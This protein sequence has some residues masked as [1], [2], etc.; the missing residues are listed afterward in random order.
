[1]WRVILKLGRLPFTILVTI[2]SVISSVTITFIIDGI[3]NRP[4]PLSGL[5]ASISAPLLLAPLFTWVILG[6]LF[7]IHHMQEEMRELATYDQLTGVY[8]RRAFLEIS[9]QYFEV[10]KREQKQIAVLFIDIDYFKKINDG[11]GHAIGDVVL[12]TVAEEISNTI[13]KSDILGRYG[14]E[15]FIISILNA[16]EEDALIV[17]EKIR[18]IVHG[19]IIVIGDHSIFASISIGIS[20]S[21]REVPT[22]L[23]DLIHEADKAMYVSKNS[24]RN[25]TTIFSADSLQREA[26]RDYRENG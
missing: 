17:A 24:G 21:R 10:A 25:R 20:I 19:K 3:M 13:R 14:G 15:E 26:A 5:I 2:F 18:N 8:S 7:R 9:N 6:L 4:I 1:M 16:G 11:Y 22:S 12:R 23:D